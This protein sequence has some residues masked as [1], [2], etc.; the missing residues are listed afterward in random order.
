MTH[1]IHWARENKMAVNL[2][3]TVEMVFRRPNVSDDFLRSIMP[4]VERIATAKLLGA[5]WLHEWI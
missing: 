5:M 1:V 3:K 4:D 2:L